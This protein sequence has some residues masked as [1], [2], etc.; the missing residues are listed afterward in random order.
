MGNDQGSNPFSSRCPYFKADQRGTLQKTLALLRL[1]LAAGLGI[2][3]GMLMA[4]AWGGGSG[5]SRRMWRPCDEENRSNAWPPETCICKHPPPPSRGEEK[6]CGESGRAERSGQS[7]PGYAGLPICPLKKSP[8][9][10]DTHLSWTKKLMFKTT[11]KGNI[12]TPDM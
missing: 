12:G 8:P 9:R 5:C 1:F 7:N 6:N 3:R 4:W 10:R 11:K 2:F